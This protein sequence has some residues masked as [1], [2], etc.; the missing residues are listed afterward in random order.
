LTSKALQFVEVAHCPACES[1]E[2]KPA[3][4]ALANLYSEQLAR[5]TSLPETAL[6]A[7]L[8]NVSCGECGLIY[9]SRWFQ[10]HIMTELFSHAVAAHPRGWDVISERF[11]LANFA[12]EIDLYEAANNQHDAAN[13]AR[14]RRAL[15]SIVDS[16]QAI[17]AP[18]VKPA[19]QNAINQQDFVELRR[20]LPIAHAQFAAPL[21]FKRF[22]GHSAPALWQWFEQQIG[23]I[24]RYGE[25]GCP[26]WGF[27]SAPIASHA[28]R[29]YI[30]RVESNYWGK[31]CQQNGLNCLSALN[32]RTQIEQI[33]FDQMPADHFDLIGIY[34]Y[35]DHVDAPFLFLQTALRASRAVALIVDS[36]EQPCTIQHRSAWPETAV[37]A[38]A[39]RLA[40]SVSSGF[41]AINGSGISLFLLWRS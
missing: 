27:L 26:L 3:P 10:S 1:A 14:Y 6:L 24:S 32:Q 17:D 22:S 21:P 38:I 39:K 41:S 8:T 13:I 40:C 4:S 30:K 34:Q 37:N 7:Q 12:G 2:Q 28:R 29:S 9:K 25:L 31:N 16:M 11:T 15:S 20:M 19:L 33:G 18:L 35:L 5:L 36:A 23:A